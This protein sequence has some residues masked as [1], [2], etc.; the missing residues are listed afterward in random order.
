MKKFR[1]TSPIGGLAL[2]LACLCG[3]AS[4]PPPLAEVARADTAIALAEQSDARTYAPVELDS[5][6]MK[7]R[8][9]R[10]SMVTEDFPTTR[11]LAEQA[12]VEAELAQAKAQ[13]GRAQQSVQQV[14]E[15]IWVL[16]EE[17]SG[18]PY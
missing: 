11:R 16:R 15:S 6:I 2:V 18:T 5:A 4:T 8:Q 3:C 14:R 13:S 1:L 10:A 9:A 17:V 7:L 12:Q